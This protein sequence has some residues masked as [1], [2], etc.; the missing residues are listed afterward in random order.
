[1]YVVEVKVLDH[2]SAAFS[3]YFIEKINIQMFS[4]SVS[5]KYIGKYIKTH[6]V[7]NHACTHNW[8]T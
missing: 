7:H 5:F 3:L 8:L 4:V 2:L 6:I 1:M